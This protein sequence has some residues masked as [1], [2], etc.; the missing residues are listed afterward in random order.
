MSV[1]SKAR[2]GAG[3]A[4]AIKCLNIT[5]LR[6]RLE[7]QGLLKPCP[8]YQGVRSRKLGR[9]K[10]VCDSSS[11]VRAV[12]YGGVRP[13][14]KGHLDVPSVRRCSK[15]KPRVSSTSGRWLCLPMLQP[16]RA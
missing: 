4:R 6:G 8:R 12:C 15:A 5:A 16:P 1:R 10:P 7:N 14:L 9:Q 13:S 3:V 11:L 2:L